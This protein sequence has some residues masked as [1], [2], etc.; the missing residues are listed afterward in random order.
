MKARLTWQRIPIKRLGLPE[1]VAAAI[2]F[3]AL[4]KTWFM[5]GQSLSIDGGYTTF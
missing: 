1:E 5:T 3:V 2:V 4:G